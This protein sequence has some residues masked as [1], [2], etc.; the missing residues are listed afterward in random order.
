MEDIEAVSRGVN[1]VS[2]GDASVFAPAGGVVEPA[3]VR[4]RS[5]AEEV[6][7][8]GTVKAYR[9]DLRRFRLWLARM[10]HLPPGEVDEVFL[11]NAEFDTTPVTAQT[12]ADYID[13]KAAEMDPVSGERR[14]AAS[15]LVRWV[16]AIG[17]VH[18]KEGWPSP[19]KD[20][21]VLEAIKVARRTNG[22]PTKRA[23]PC[24]LSRCGRRCCRLTL[25]GS[26]TVSSARE[27]RR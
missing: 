1:V 3:G 6:A 16:A 14:F 25:P 22:R 18:Q 13:L 17:W 12:V 19:T 2:S 26:S 11:A 9:S 10:D 4:R 7:A 23:A 20:P 15:T 27:T 8:V 21:V 5:R 24:C